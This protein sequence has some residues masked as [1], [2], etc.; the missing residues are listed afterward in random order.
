MNIRGK[1]NHKLNKEK[2]KYY[3]FILIHT[4]KLI[5][6]NDII[7]RMIWWTSMHFN[8]FNINYKNLMEFKA[9][10]LHTIYNS[11]YQKKMKNSCQ[12]NGKSW[13]KKKLNAPKTFNLWQTSYLIRCISCSDTT[14]FKKVFLFKKV[15]PLELPF[16]TK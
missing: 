8:T 6:Q 4:L 13:H 1:K 14:Y 10:M 2:D 3:Y 11:L 7:Y 9:N 15:E 12:K 16:R 5:S